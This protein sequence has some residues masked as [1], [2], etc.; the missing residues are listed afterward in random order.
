M[1]TQ[2]NPKKF[3][4][5]IRFLTKSDLID[6][7][8]ILETWIKDRITSS[9]LLDE[10]EETLQNM[11]ASIDKSNS[12]VYLVA[13]EG[14]L[15]VGVI[16]FKN[17]DQKMIAFARTSNPAELINAYVRIDERGGRGIGR[18]LVDLLENEAI[19]QGFTE[20]ILNSGP[21]FKETGWGFY[22]KLPNYERIGIAENYYGQGADAPVWSKIL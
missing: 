15:V 5:I 18:A 10:V 3:A 7:K 6:I 13:E 16:G 8:S 12:R 9:P 17:P 2:V 4:G 20:I 14:G 11:R 19:K 1:T 22:D 21:R